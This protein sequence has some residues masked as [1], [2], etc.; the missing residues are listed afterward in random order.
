MEAPE[1]GGTGLGWGATLSP[2][3]CLPAQDPLSMR[4]HDTAFPPQGLCLPFAQRQVR[5]SDVQ[6][7]FLSSEPE[8]HFSGA[9]VLPSGREALWA[10][11]DDDF[12]WD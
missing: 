10:P 9:M 7:P 5:P 3:S 12:L 11:S 6:R 8:F 2:A 4:H 1:G